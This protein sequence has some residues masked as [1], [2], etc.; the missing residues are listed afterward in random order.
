[1][2]ALESEEAFATAEDGARIFYRVSGRGPFALVMPVTW[3]MDSYVYTKGLS[4]LEFYLALVTFDPRGVGR[5]DPASAGEALSL[6]TAAGDAAVVAEAVGLSRSVVIGHSG[7]GALAMAYA[8]RFPERVSHLILLSSAAKWDAPSPLPSGPHLPVTEDEMRESMRL[9]VARAVR[10]PKRFARA[11]DELLPKMR[12]SPARLRWAAEVGIHR[13]DFR[14]DLAAIRAPTL[15]LHGRED[16]MVPL[17]RAKE[18]HEGIPG[19]KLVVLEDCGHW[20][21]VEKRTEFVSA[22]KVFLDIDD[23]VV[24]SF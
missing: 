7:G 22:V 16:P 18:I 20:P 12:F 11:M 13:Y 5:S 24:R 4:S 15:I 2:C 23:R 10:D 8:L 3:G 19:S 14:G 9:A 21:H 6:E 1:M 17:D